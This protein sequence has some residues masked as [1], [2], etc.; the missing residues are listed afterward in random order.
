MTSIAD[1]DS[2]VNDNAGTMDIRGVKVKVLQ[3][4]LAR[5]ILFNRAERVFIK[6]HSAVKL[7]DKVLQIRMLNDKNQIQTFF[8]N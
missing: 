4:V 8:S 2:D 6:G 3:N 1:D 7:T 5:L